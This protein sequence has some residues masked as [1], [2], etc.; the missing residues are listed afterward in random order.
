MYPCVF[1]LRVA[2]SAGGAPLCVRRVGFLSGRGSPLRVPLRVGCLL[3]CLLRARVGFRV[4]GPQR[5]WRMRLAAPRPMGPSQTVSPASAGG[6]FTNS[7]VITV[8]YVTSQYLCILLSFSLSTTFI[9]HHPPLPCQVTTN[10]IT[11]SI[12]LVFLFSQRNDVIWLWFLFTLY[13]SCVLKIQW[14]VR[15]R[16]GNRPASSP[17]WGRSGC[18]SK[19]DSKGGGG[20]GEKRVAARSIQEGE[21]SARTVWAG[22][23]GNRLESRMASKFFPGS[24]QY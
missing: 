19:G 18:F 23:L 1:L 7:I 15:G 4:R 22:G 12:S 2:S 8:F 17:R 21:M 24:S 5:S 6:F 3:Q 10:L 14:T 16:A 9:Q 20:N 11:F 13:D